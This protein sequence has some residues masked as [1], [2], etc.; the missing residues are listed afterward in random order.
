MA[1]QGIDQTQRSISEPWGTF[2]VW[3]EVSAPRT[4][5]TPSHTTMFSTLQIDPLVRTIFEALIL[6]RRF[7]GP[8]DAARSFC[9]ERAHGSSVSI[10]G[11]LA[12]CHVPASNVASATGLVFSDFVR[13]WWSLNLAAL[14]HLLSRAC[15]DDG[16]TWVSCPYFQ[17]LCPVVCS[18]AS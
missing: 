9:I 4:Q 18:S 10:E 6:P 1:R 2:M 16:D 13:L 5:Q 12:C 8:K 17:P 15:F 11:F 3:L 14:D 7:Q